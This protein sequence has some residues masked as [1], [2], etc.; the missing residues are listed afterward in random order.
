[1]EQPIRIASSLGDSVTRPFPSAFTTLPFEQ[2]RRRWF[3]TCSCKPIPR[4]RP[5][6]VEQLRTS[7]AFRPFAVLVAHYNRE[8]ADLNRSDVLLHIPYRRAMM[9]WTPPGDSQ[10][11]SHG[12]W[13]G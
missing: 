1:M 4:G 9:R 7:S 13:L 3:G 10:C 2:S 11:K 5:S 12:N 8:T 6:S